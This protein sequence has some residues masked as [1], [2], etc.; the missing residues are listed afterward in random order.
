M[1]TEHLG[2][3]YEYLLEVGILANV[4]IKKSQSYFVSDPHEIIYN[5]DLIVVLANLFFLQQLKI[6]FGD[7][8]IL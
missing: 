1:T 4:F 3:D 5:S 8:L 7:G 6:Y 2:E